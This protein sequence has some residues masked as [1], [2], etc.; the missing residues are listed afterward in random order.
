MSTGDKKFQDLFK[1]FFKTNTRAS[2]TA[3]G[4][5]KYKTE[6]V[7]K[8]DVFAEISAPNPPAVRLKAL[9]DLS[10]IVEKKRLEEN[11]TEVFWNCLQDF[12]SP[13]VPVEHRHQVYEFLRNLII[14]QRERFAVPMWLKILH[15][16]KNSKELEDL[17]WMIEILNALTSNGRNLCENEDQISGY[18]YVTLPKAQKTGHGVQ[19]LSFILNL[20]KFHASCL[21]D[22]FTIKLTR[23][24]CHLCCT[25]KT[26]A[27]VSKTLEILD[28]IVKYSLLRIES[29]QAMVTT[30]CRLVNLEKHCSVA[31]TIMRNI[32][33]TSVGTTA[34]YTLIR[35]CEKAH[36]DPVLLRG[37][38]FFLSLS[39]WGGP[40]I[41]VQK[42]QNQVQISPLLILPAFKK[43]LKANHPL[44]TYECLQAI[45]RLIEVQRG[46]VLSLV[47]SSVFQLLETINSLQSNPYIAGLY[48]SILDSIENLIEHE[49]FHGDLDIFYSCIQLCSASRPESSVMKLINYKKDFF[50]PIYP[51]WIEQMESFIDAFYTKEKRPVIQTRAIEVLGSVIDFNRKMYGDELLEDVFI[52]RFS[53]VSCGQDV[54]VRKAVVNVAVEACIPCNCKHYEKLMAILRKIMNINFDGSRSSEK[55]LTNEDFEDALEAVKGAIKIFK[56]KIFEVPSFHARIAYRLLL[57]HVQNHLKCDMA[58]EN[59]TEAK[60]LIF[61]TFLQLRADSLYRIGLAHEQKYSP[62]LLVDHKFGEDSSLDSQAPVKDTPRITPGPNQPSNITYVS[63]TDTCF[64]VIKGLLVEREWKILGLL[65]RE[66]P[67]ILSNKSLILSKNTNNIGEVCSKLCQLVPGSTNITPSVIRNA[68]PD[69]NRYKFLSLVFPILTCFPSYHVQLNS[70]VEQQL[71]KTLEKG[72]GNVHIISRV[73]ISALTLCTLEMQDTMHKLIQSILFTISKV[74][75]TVVVAEPMLVFLSTLVRLPKVYSDFKV[76]HFMAV[77]AIAVQF[78]NPSKFNRYT[79]SLAYYVI[80]IWFLKLKPSFVKNCIRYITE[81]LKI[82]IETLLEQ[83]NI[84]S[85]ELTEDISIRRRSASLTDKVGRRRLEGLRP[86][87]IDESV[88]QYHMDMIETCMDLL[89]RYA[90]AAY[91][92]KPKRSSLIE[93]I[94][95]NGQYQ[96]WIMGNTLITMTT[97]GCTRV[98]TKPDLCEK[99]WLNCRFEVKE[100]ESTAPDGAELG[101]SPSQSVDRR[102]RHKTEQVRKLSNE[103]LLERDDKRLSRDDFYTQ[104]SLRSDSDLHRISFGVGEEK[105]GAENGEPLKRCICWCQNW[106]E[107]HVRRPAGDTAWVMRIENDGLNVGDACNPRDNITSIF[108]PDLGHKPNNA[109]IQDEVFEDLRALQ[110]RFHSI[111]ATDSTESDEDI[112]LKENGEGHIG[113]GDAKVRR[114]SSTKERKSYDVIPEEQ[115]SS[116]GGKET[117]IPLGMGIP[118]TKDVE[119]SE[120]IKVTERRDRYLADDT[121]PFDG[122]SYVVRGRTQTMPSS[123]SGI[124]R[125]V[126][127]I[128]DKKQESVLKTKEAKEAVK[129]G[130]NT[131]FLFLQLYYLR[132]IE[133]GE[134][135]DPPILIGPDRSDIELSIRNLDKTSCYETHKIGVIYVGSSQ[136]KDETEI[137]S[138]KYGSARYQEFLRGLGSLIRLKSA[139]SAAVFLGGL[140]TDGNDGDYTYTWNDG[141]AQVVFHVATL[142]PNKAKD[143]KCN[144]KKR[145]IGNNFVTIVYNNSG[146]EYDISTIRCQFTHACVIVEPLEMGTNYA[147][148]KGRPEVAEMQYYAQEKTLIS[149]VNLALFVRQLAVHANIVSKVISSRNG[150]TAQA[151]MDPYG[152]NWLHRLRQIKKIRA[153]LQPSVDTSEEKEKV[154]T[155]SQKKF[156]VKDFTE[157]V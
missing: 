12:F 100:G 9:K 97:S 130:F 5:P 139:D 118:P 153:K 85:S 44:V 99:C 122:E 17:Y 56:K 83:Q 7:V 49:L 19:L 152:S 31:W 71:V 109:D 144:D 126:P 73:C 55:I 39:Q 6:Y 27:E 41:Q 63:L 107:V 141:I 53:D 26:V 114:Q 20:V 48:H 28:A 54:Q 35:Y 91:S 32:I 89:G 157:F 2:S 29:L 101:S 69:F 3:T 33:G 137:L 18:I 94:F 132:A 42:T 117:S 88:M 113:E 13:S 115:L 67:K 10:E 106:A 116:S 36:S 77:F 84:R 64:T 111:G 4:N 110:T 59:A 135:V 119:T 57:E 102:R 103:G 150:Q 129:S 121:L 65:L 68:P 155:K 133:T 140:D 81:G 145:H 92:A 79:V 149:D 30:L 128:F 51:D 124:R 78:T 70:K 125:P 46:E 131:N 123:M 156:K 74:S 105:N 76:D 87:D 104:N 93:K 16:I 146:E 62:Y 60:Y 108:L 61:D 23:M 52:P 11:A 40:S 50:T 14:G 143:P 127:S 90:F 96:S 147:F 86:D 142:M 82:N 37:A 45:Y 136:A 8:P 148:I 15:F 21:S 1:Q 154:V 38:I 43:A 24:L 22:A 95:K 47:W 98:A 34:V 120:T 58:V 134:D 25:S 138:N 66:V 80:G 72:V 151:L 112:H 75:A